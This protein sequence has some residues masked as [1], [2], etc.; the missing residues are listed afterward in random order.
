MHC[1]GPSGP[2]TDSSQAA[3]PA[4]TAYP[5]FSE[6]KIIKEYL[7]RYTNPFPI[8]H[9]RVHT[10]CKPLLA[11]L[12]A[13]K[14]KTDEQKDLVNNVII[15][16]K[17]CCLEMAGTHVCVYCNTITDDTTGGFCRGE[18]IYQCMKGGKHP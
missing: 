10:H 18:K 7:Y 11:C 16:Y 14:G 8:K 12:P 1:D 13:Q 4:S 2:T 6:K 17:F 15:M 9:A 5:I 3:E